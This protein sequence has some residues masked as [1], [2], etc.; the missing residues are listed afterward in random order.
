RALDDAPTRR[1]VV[2]ERAVLARLEAGCAAPIGAWGRV[3]EATGTLVLDAVVAAVDGS[4]VLRL[5][6]R[7]PAKDDRDADA[8]GRR[9]ADDLLAAGAADLAPVGP[10][11]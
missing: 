11:R 7:G 5:A 1:A 6:A 4:R 3:D 8:L 9:L 2:A 10:T